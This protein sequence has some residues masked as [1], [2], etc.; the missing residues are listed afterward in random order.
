MLGFSCTKPPAFFLAGDSTTAVQSS[1]GGGWGNGFLSFLKSPAWGINY[2]HNGATTVSFVAGGDWSRVVGSLKNNSASYDCYVTIQ[3]GHN[4]QKPAANISLSQYQT[5]LENLAGEVKTAG[6]TP[7]LVTPLTRR[8][9][10]SDHNATDSLHNER[11]ATIAA[12]KASST[13]YI[14][15]NAASL[16]YVDAIGNA[17]AQVYDLNGNDTTHLNDYGSVVFGRMVADLLLGHP[18]VVHGDA[19]Y[20]EDPCLERWIKPNETLSSN[21][22]AGLPA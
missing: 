20:T 16:A 5:N 17:S 11:L 22:W 14:D 12:A 21:I 18:P 3:F 10:T 2:G 8:A 1:G 4:D 19:H 7:I 6:G 15:L 13:R 9:F